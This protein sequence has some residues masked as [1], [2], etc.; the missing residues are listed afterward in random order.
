MPVLRFTFDYSNTNFVVQNMLWKCK[1]LLTTM[2]SVTKRNS[3]KRFLINDYLFLYVQFLFKLH[4]FF[5]VF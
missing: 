1:S 3:Q 4:S 2:Q 5:S